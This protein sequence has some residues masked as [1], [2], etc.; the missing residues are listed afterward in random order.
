MNNTDELNKN[1]PYALIDIFK[2]CV[3]DETSNLKT[4]KTNCSFFKLDSCYQR[5]IGNRNDSD[6]I[7]LFT[8]Y[9]P[10]VRDALFQIYYNYFLKFDI[11]PEKDFTDHFWNTTTKEQI[12]CY[13][14]IIKFFEN[15]RLNNEERANKEKEESTFYKKD[16]AEKLANLNEMFRSEQEQML[17][18][19]VGTEIVNN[20]NN[21]PI[22]Q[23]VID[24]TKNNNEKYITMFENFTINETAA[25]DEDVTSALINIFKYCVK[26]KA[27]NLIIKH[28][29]SCK[30]F[31]KCFQQYYYT[32]PLKY[33]L[34]TIYTKY[35]KKFKICEENEFTDHFYN[36]NTQERI[37]CYYLIINFFKN[38]IFP[39]NDGQFSENQKPMILMMSNVVGQKVRKTM[40]NI[41][42]IQDVIAAT[43]NK[44]ENKHYIT[45]FKNFP[46]NNSNKNN[47]R[48][49]G[50]SKSYS[51]N[52]TRY[53][54]NLRIHKQKKHKKTK[55]RKTKT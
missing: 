44:R 55:K 9:K 26:A 35:F 18:T 12:Y 2:Y 19:V 37:Y 43:Q 33:A 1:V 30:T 6:L 36:T 54:S 28:G 50:G 51:K 8:T 47:Y 16:R 32:M 25:S 14:L 46:I 52:R 27:S 34:N 38:D 24:A 20:M 7:L 22:I 45:M 42:I 15:A 40:K 49:I 29:T 4:S 23:L 41:K 17:S 3:N 13:Y 31:E 39:S 11:C 48:S 5:S 53:N 21:L 10:I